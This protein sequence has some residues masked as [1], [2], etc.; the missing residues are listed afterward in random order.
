MQNLKSAPLLKNNKLLQQ[1]SHSPFNHAFQLPQRKK[2]KPYIEHFADDKYEKINFNNLKQTANQKNIAYNSDEEDLKL[3]SS[4]VEIAK[5][6]CGVEDFYPNGKPPL[7]DIKAMR[8]TINEYIQELAKTNPDMEN[9]CVRQMKDEH[10]DIFK[11]I[12]ESPSVALNILPFGFQPPTEEQVKKVFDTD[13]QNGNIMF[14]IRDTQDDKVLGCF[15]VRFR[16]AQ[17]PSKEGGYKEMIVPEVWSKMSTPSKGAMTLLRKLQEEMYNSG[18]V[19]SYARVG[20][21]AYEKYANFHKTTEKY[22][23]MIPSLSVPGAEGVAI[24]VQTFYGY[25]DKTKEEITKDEIF[26]LDN[27]A[28][29]LANISPTAKK[30]TVTSKTLSDLKQSNDLARPIF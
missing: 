18:F 1:F 4:K 8:N 21:H 2:E 9:K 17:M 13:S 28:I 30:G 14:A 11:E 19:V 12:C 26:F 16:S 29:Q 24:D 20:N 3:A 5:P 7:P 6:K 22:L 10:Y 23:K 27:L 25:K 15:G